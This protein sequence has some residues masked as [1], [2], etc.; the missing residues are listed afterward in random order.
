MASTAALTIFLMGTLA[1]GAEI[2]IVP[3]S[4]L[5]LGG[6]ELGA[7]A[8]SV[9]AVLGNPSAERQ[10]HDFLPVEMSYVGITVWLD[11]AGR[12]GEILSA[13]PKYC[14]PQG[15]CPG[16]PFS[17]VQALYGKPMVALREDGR[18]MEY[19]PASDFPCWLQIAVES[20]RVRS[21]RSECQP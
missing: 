16:Q 14:T 20:D 2:S 1:P 18:Y 10:T 5:S 9:K 15:A 21:I 13:S 7:P 17:A 11:E 8:A 4:A 12:V 3:D 6:I 19:Y